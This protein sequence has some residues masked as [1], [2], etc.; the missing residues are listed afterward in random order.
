MPL[1]NWISDVSLFKAVQKLLRAT[2]AAKKKALIK[3]STNVMDPFSAI[4]QMAGFSMTY[5]EWFKSEEA[6][7]AQKTMQNFVG[8]FHQEVLGY[9]SG[10]HDMGR[11]QI[12]DLVNSQ[13]QIIAEVKN[14]H[15]TIS[16]G[17]LYNL[18]A[19][20]EE[21]VMP[22]NSKYKGFT[23]Y[24]VSVV[25]KKPT[26]YDKQFTPANKTTGTKCAE[27]DLIRTIDGASFYT[28]V[29]GDQN[30]LRDLFSALP[31]VLSQFNVQQVD[32]AKLQ[33]LY[34]MAYG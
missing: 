9:C 20:L 7:Q 21:L 5:D 22:K 19:G 8:E 25:P 3:I 1:L 32:I 26:R 27:N 10:W 16:G 2:Q 30:A 33:N 17:S 28:I 4:F 24:H 6:R 11:G 23:A 14:K 29:T 31:K 13:K 15:N 12:I 18:Y 34:Q